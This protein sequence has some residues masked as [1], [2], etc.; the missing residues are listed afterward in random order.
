MSRLK[1]GTR[2]GLPAVLGDEE[3]N[4]WV[5][6]FLEY[7]RVERGL[8]ANTLEAY[9]GDIHRFA[10][11]IRTAGCRSILAAESDLIRAFLI[12]ERRRGIEAASLSRALV[13][14]RVLYRFLTAEKAVPANPARALELP[15]TTKA[16]PSFFSRPEVNA[17]LADVRSDKSWEG[18]RDRA[19]LELL[20]AAGLRASEICALKR[21]QI[22]REE[23]IL[24]VRGKG[25]KER[26]VPFGR[27]AAE[28]LTDY[29]SAS[30]KRWPGHPPQGEEAFFWNAWRKPIR[31]QGLWRIVRE[32]TRAALKTGKR[33]YP[34]MLRHTFA[35]HLLE[36]GADLRVLQEM[37]GHSDVATTQIYT[38]V[39][40]SRLKKIHRQF[41]PR[42]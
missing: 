11:W 21:A 27:E 13:A 25:G 20:Y 9:R 30:A 5:G 6:R 31:R 15:K 33:A 18:C 39:D 24:R 8:A 10:A 2:S 16:L 40:Q 4:L 23:C 42:A 41:H 29:D 32:R 37:L 17:L 1:R 7:L 36:G 19:I 34:H 12:G 14:L 28:A 26:L 22:D 35:T 38:H 3:S